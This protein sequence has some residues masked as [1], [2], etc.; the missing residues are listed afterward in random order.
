M[1]SCALHL[2]Q[3]R[4]HASSSFPQLHHS[5]SF[6]AGHRRTCDGASA[7]AASQFQTAR[8]CLK[9]QQGPG[10]LRL[11]L[12]I[13]CMVDLFVPPA[14]CYSG[15]MQRCLLA[16]GVVGS[17]SSPCM[18]AA[19]LSFIVLSLLYTGRQTACPHAGKCHPSTVVLRLSSSLVGRVSTVLMS[20][21][22]RQPT[23]SRNGALSATTARHCA[24]ALLGILRRHL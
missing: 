8:T 2:L 5:L 17:N 12:S 23:C 19:L 15:C 3:A 18:H 24:P 1:Q 21:D 22:H 4:R 7:H 14:S 16:G 11:L 20:Y 6:D 10:P 9:L 13:W